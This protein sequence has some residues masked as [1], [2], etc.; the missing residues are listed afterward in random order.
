MGLGTARSSGVCTQALCCQPPHL[1]PTILTSVPGAVK[2]KKK[3][4]KKPPA[5]RA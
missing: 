5:N 1:L 3:K 2:K 4:Y